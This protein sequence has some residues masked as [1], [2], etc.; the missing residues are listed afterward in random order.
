MIQ[1]KWFAPGQ[2]IS[3]EVLPVRACVFGGSSWESTDPEGWNALVY[4]DGCP[5]AAGRIWWQD[6][7]FWLGYI[8]VLEG[9]RGQHLGDL[10]LRLHLFKAQS[11]AAREVRLICPDGT[12]RA[13]AF[14]QGAEP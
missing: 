11:H 13:G 4:S 10:V 5:V 3:D 7:V 14:R 8:G 6:D 12:S 9:Y 1:G 2:D